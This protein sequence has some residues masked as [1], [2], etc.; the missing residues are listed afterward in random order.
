MRRS[1][2][3]AL[4]AALATVG[5]IAA[6]GIAQNSG[7]TNTPPPT[8]KQA[9][10][11]EQ[12]QRDDR[13]AAVAKRLDT[14]AA[15]LKAAVKKA[16]QAQLDADVA[17]NRLTA[18]QRDAILACQ[19]DP[20]T[21]DRSNLPAFRHGHG[22]DD[23]KNGTAKKDTPPTQ[24]EM[25]AKRKE[26]QARQDAFYAAIGKEIGKTGDEVRKAFEAERPARGDH[27]GPDGPGGPG[28]RGGH[29]HGHGPDGDGP[30]G[31]GGPGFGPGF[32]P[33]P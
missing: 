32:A 31:P 5:V 24:A 18:A 28:G 15:E 2:L 21:C 25:D 23:D 10:A 7:S 29:G 26:M 8:Q 16:Q 11:T 9:Q 27:G 12:K 22:R 14:T 3:T 17:A 30:G 4:A 13:A 20:L 33:G 6:T 1:I 19:D